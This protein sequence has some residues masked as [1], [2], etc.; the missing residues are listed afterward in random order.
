MRDE[1]LALLLEGYCFT[2]TRRSPGTSAF[3]TRLGGRR[4]LVVGGQDG[5]RLFY[6]TERMRRHGAI[7]APTRRALFGKGAVHGLDGDAHAQRKSMFLALLDRPAVE[8]VTGAAGRRWSSLFD[9]WPAGTAMAVQPAAA[10]V[11]GGAALDWVGI[12]A[13]QQQVQLRSR[14]LFD[15]VDGFGSFGP[16]WTRSVVARQRSQRWIRGALVRA[17]A[18]PEAAPPVLRTVATHRDRDGSLLDLDVATVE[19]HNLL[20]PTVAVSWLVTYSVLALAADHALR[21]RVAADEP[22]VVEAFAHEVR[23]LYPFVPLLAAVATCDFDW[24]GHSVRRG[25]LVVLDV[26]GTHHDPTAWPEPA[27][28]RVDR[29][30]GREPGPFELLAQGGGD[31]RTGHRCPGEPLTVELVK[32]AARRFAAAD[33]S[34]EA[35]AQRPLRRMPPDLTRVRIRRGV[36]G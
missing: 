22:G 5:A 8:Q 10:R 32:D 3:V 13:S 2:P 27:D 9:E 36:S 4:A 33:W 24:Q 11:L 28:F 16:R 21:V 23:R 17:R 30:L 35:A 14:E 7:P 26:V 19:V 31:R 1:S 6:D 20:R 25:Q 15:V 29:F 18:F 34:L 12:S